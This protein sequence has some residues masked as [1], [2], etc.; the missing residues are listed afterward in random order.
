[1]S[2]PDPRTE[3]RM[4]GLDSEV[5]T[6]PP[7]PRSQNR[8]Y[9]LSGFGSLTEYHPYVT[10]QS[11]VIPKDRAAAPLPKFLPLQRLSTTRS[12]LPPAG[13]TPP[14]TL[15]PQG[16]APS[17]RLAP[18]MAF[19]ACSIPVPLM[20]FYPSRPLSSPGAVRPFR[21]RAPRGFLSTKK[22]R[23]PL[24]GLPHRANPSDRSGG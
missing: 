4:V 21:R 19:R 2:L 15:R 13:P 10:A 7:F 5:S 12:H 8:G 1:M 24:Q 3:I 23:P 18:L 20:G 22:K 16:F 9:P 6:P 14:V 17:R 11:S